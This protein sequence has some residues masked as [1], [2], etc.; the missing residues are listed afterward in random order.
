MREH[1][2]TFLKFH[3]LKVEILFTDEEGKEERETKKS[4]VLQRRPWN[5]WEW[6]LFF[7][8]LLLSNMFYPISIPD[9]ET[10]S[11]RDEAIIPTESN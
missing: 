10:K 4:M 5:I 11:K 3:F 1:R 7:E 6:E 8:C 9:G 2:K